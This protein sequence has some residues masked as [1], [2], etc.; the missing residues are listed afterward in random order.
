VPAD[1]LLDEALETA[2]KIATFSQP[3]GSPNKQPVAQAAGWGQSKW[4]SSA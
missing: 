3:I 2:G 1:S 4:P